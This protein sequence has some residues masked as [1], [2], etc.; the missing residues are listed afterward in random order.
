MAEE[1]DTPEEPK[2]NRFAR[3][4]VR[5]IEVALIVDRDHERAFVRALKER[6]P[7]KDRHA[8][9]EKLTA[10]ARWWGA[11]AGFTTGLPANPWAAL[12]AAV[13]DVAM[14]LR[15]EVLLAIRVGLLFDDKFL[16]DGE[17]PYEVLVPIFGGRAAGELVRESA[18]RGA[19]GGTRAAIKKF[20]T[21]NALKQF[22][23]VMLK[24]FGL[25]VT[26]RGLITKTVPIVGGVIGAGW[27]FGEIHF[28]GR[29]VYRYFDGH[30][31]DEDDGSVAPPA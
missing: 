22:Q 25:K 20:L 18:M 19:M 13:T 16:D 24:Y 17:P 26:Q 23:R 1:N 4:L 14:T 28:V 29:R 12:P 8:L 30:H 9:T 27:N 11:G 10:R 15:V 6:Y 2:A 5:A 31:I 3:M 7:G 21:G